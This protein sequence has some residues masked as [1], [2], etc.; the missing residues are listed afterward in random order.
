MINT[1]IDLKEISQEHADGLS[2][3]FKIKGYIPSKAVISSEQHLYQQ[4]KYRKLY[5]INSF[6]AQMLEELH[7]LSTYNSRTVKYSRDAA[8]LELRKSI[9]P[10]TD[11]L[12][13]DEKYANKVTTSADE[14]SSW[15][16]ILSAEEPA[17]KYYASLDVPITGVQ[18]ISTHLCNCNYLPTQSCDGYE[19]LQ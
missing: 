6:S 4:M 13:Y 8:I 9:K 7:A 18:V 3:F 19:L 14:R 5:I 2:T 10:L 11:Q 16:T 12:F 15:L 1:E 17:V